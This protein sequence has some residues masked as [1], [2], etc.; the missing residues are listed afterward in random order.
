MALSMWEFIH[1]TMG[2]EDLILMFA[3]PFLIFAGIFLFA[4]STTGGKI[5]DFFIDRHKAR[6]YA[7]AIKT[8]NK[9][10]GRY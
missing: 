5:I 7:K 10:E 3:I 9:Y 4:C 1:H 6:K 2:I 8:I